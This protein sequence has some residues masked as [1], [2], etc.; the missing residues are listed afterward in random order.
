MIDLVRNLESIDKESSKYTSFDSIPLVVITGASANRYVEI[1]DE[2]LRAEA[3]KL[4]N[5]MQKDLLNLSTNSRQILAETKDSQT[6]NHGRAPHKLC[7]E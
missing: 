4:W 7:S 2:D 3:I 1:R 5:E 6:K